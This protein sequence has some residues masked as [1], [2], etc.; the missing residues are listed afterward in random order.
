MN[1]RYRITLT[2]EERDQRRAVVLAGKG[3]FHA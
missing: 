1:A 2:S 3:A